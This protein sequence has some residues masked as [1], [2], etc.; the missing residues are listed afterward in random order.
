MKNSTLLIQPLSLAEAQKKRENQHTY[1][2]CIILTHDHRILLQL[3]DAGFKKFASCISAFGG[4]IEED[5]TPEQTIC[6]E[7]NEELGAKV[8][9]S[10]LVFI[11]AY[12]EA[13]THFT[14]VIYGY[15]WHD[16]HNTITGCFEGSPLYCS[17][18]QEALKQPDL[19]DDV[20]WLLEQCQEQKLIRERL[21]H[22]VTPSSLQPIERVI[23]DI[24]SI[25]KFSTHRLIARRIES[26]DLELLAEMDS[27]P[28]VMATLGGV[29]TREETEARLAWNLKQWEDNSHGLWLFFLK[30]TGKFIGRA[31]LRRMIVDDKD[32]LELGYALM[33]D[34]WGKGFATEMAQACIE[35][36]FDYLDYENI[37]CFT[38][39]T[40]APSRRV[41]EKLGFQYEK[42]CMHA[43]TP[44]VL[45]RLC[46][47]KKNLSKTE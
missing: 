15:F 26:M 40:N 39:L 42:N 1:T 43:N 33:P 29:K 35:I 14:D 20:R 6:R 7:L 34:F 45:Y 30:E 31:S 10:E 38:A 32:E 18:A 12:T 46:N 41:M 4:C 16:K 21:A 11:S 27:H 47:P 24:H 28:M 25:E 17:S 13:V 44:H 36:A 9:A 37:A 22:S 19:M 5:E 8:A 2:G 3:R 23:T